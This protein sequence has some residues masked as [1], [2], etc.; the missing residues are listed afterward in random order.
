MTFDGKSRWL[1]GVLAVLGGSVFLSGCSTAAPTTPDS[2]LVAALAT[3]EAGR[4]ATLSSSAIVYCPRCY[5]LIDPVRVPGNIP[6]MVFL[7]MINAGTERV[8]NV[9][10]TGNLLGAR[11]E[12]VRVAEVDQAGP[13]PREAVSFKVHFQVP[14]ELPPGPYRVEMVFDPENPDLPSHTW[15]SDQILTIP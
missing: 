14:P 2:E 8:G 3:S 1:A 11:G 5:W 4:V 12:R 15:V 7:S 6:V 9:H 13:G 10:V